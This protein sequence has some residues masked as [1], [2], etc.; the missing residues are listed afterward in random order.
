MAKLYK[1]YTNAIPFHHLKILIYEASK[2]LPFK[3]C[4]LAPVHFLCA[5]D[6]KI[7]RGMGLMGPKSPVPT[8]PGE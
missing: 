3:N 4:F 7:A 8:V 6:L 1:A 2:I 5:R